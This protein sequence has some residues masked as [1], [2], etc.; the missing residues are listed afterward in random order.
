LKKAV[1]GCLKAIAGRED[2]EVTFAADRPV[3]TGNSARLPEPPRRMSA[4]DGA[5]LRGLSDAMALRLACHDTKLH[6]SMAPDGQA[7]RA[8]TMRWNR[9]VSRPSA[10]VA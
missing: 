4:E 10:P 6:K 9:P 3:L 8:S 1:S 2:V 5:I 7:A